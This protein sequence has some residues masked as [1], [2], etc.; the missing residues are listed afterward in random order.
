MDTPPGM[1]KCRALKRGRNLVTEGNRFDP[2]S[3]DIHYRLI[4]HNVF[5]CGR[6]RL[7]TRAS[8]RFAR[9]TPVG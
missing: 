4:S 6:A 3:M 7:P 8:K 1:E 5:F 2:R 9:P